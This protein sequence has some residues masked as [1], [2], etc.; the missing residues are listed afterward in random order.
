MSK[1]YYLVEGRDTCM[2]ILE[3]HEITKFMSKSNPKI[4]TKVQF[5]WPGEKNDTEVTYTGSIVEISGNN[6][7]LNFF[8]FL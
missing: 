3:H 6:I 7:N 5:I 4:G 8:F 2:Y 1:P